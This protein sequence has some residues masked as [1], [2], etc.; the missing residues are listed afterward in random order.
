M[1]LIANGYKGSTARTGVAYCYTGSW[2]SS[3]TTKTI[4]VPLSIGGMPTTSGSTTYAVHKNVVVGTPMVITTS[5]S[6]S[7]AG[8]S[9]TVGAIY[10]SGNYWMASISLKKSVGPSYSDQGLYVTVNWSFEQIK[11]DLYSAL[12]MGNTTFSLKTDKQFS[13]M[14]SISSV[15]INTSGSI[16]GYLTIYWP[17]RLAARCDWSAYIENSDGSSDYGTQDVYLTYGTNNLKIYLDNISP[18]YWEIEALIY[19]NLEGYNY[20]WSS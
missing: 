13:S 14:G 11:P 2:T 12:T 15:G 1:A 6:Q 7:V 3:Q 20:Y 9:I 18:D 17:Y 4:T 10:I 5:F 16:Y 19:N 8:G